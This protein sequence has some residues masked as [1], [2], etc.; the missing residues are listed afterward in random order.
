MIES[1]EW[2][3]A[4]LSVCCAGWVTLSDS[5]YRRSVLSEAGGDIKGVIED[6]VRQIL[7]EN[8]VEAQIV[9]LAS[10]Y[11]KRSTVVC[12][13]SCFSSAMKLLNLAKSFRDL[14]KKLEIDLQKSLDAF[15]SECAAS[16]VTL[17]TADIVSDSPNARRKQPSSSL[18]ETPSRK[19]LRKE[20][21]N[22]PTRL[23]VDTTIVENKSALAVRIYCLLYIK[24]TVC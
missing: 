2:R 21:L 15:V 3:L 17:H 7:S 6:L 9:V 24:F 16:L 5:R 13:N 11:L 20:A 1:T 23:F 19:R 18:S 22:T 14:H 10:A 4:F 12:R 8:V